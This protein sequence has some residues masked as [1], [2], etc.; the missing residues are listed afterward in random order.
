MRRT[1]GLGKLVFLVFTFMAFSAAARADEVLLVKE[2]AVPQYVL[3]G[4]GVAAKMFGR[5]KDVYMGVLTLQPGAVVPRHHH[6]KA[7][8]ILYFL[9]GR[10]IFTIDGKEYKIGP[11]MAIYIPPLTDHSFRVTSKNAVVAVQIW[12]PAGPEVKYLNWKKVEKK[13]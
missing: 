12:T 2:R 13:R 7:A 3:E 4:K 1:L 10:G 11:H 8:E 9:K 5:K 6:E